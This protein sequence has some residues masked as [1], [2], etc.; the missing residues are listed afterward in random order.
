[1]YLDNSS[2]KERSVNGYTVTDF[3]PRYSFSALGLKNVDLIASVNNIF[4][5][6]YEVGGYTY[7]NLTPTGDRVFYN[8]YTPQATTNYML[9]L[10]I[11]F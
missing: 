6:K 4:N 1:M 11:K 8:F 3:S 9:S 2:S 5:K 10:N 7:G